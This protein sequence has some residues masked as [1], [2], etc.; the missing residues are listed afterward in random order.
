[1]YR[2]VH[3]ALLEDVTNVTG[4]GL[5]SYAQVTWGNGLVD[6]DNDGD[7]DLYI[8]CGHLYDNVEHFD[9]QSSYRATNLLYENVGQGKFLEV[10]RQAGSGLAVKLSSRGAA[11]DDLDND[12]DVDI[13]VLNSRSEPTLLRNESAHGNHWIELVLQGTTCNRDGVGSQVEVV[14]DSLVQ[15][16]EVHSGRGYQGHFGSVLHFGLGQRGRVH[17]VRVRWLGGA[18]E[19]WRDLTVDRRHT[20]RQGG[21]TP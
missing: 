18:T 11:F 16:D 10:S 2:N 9:D 5:G 4:A 17:E 14:A 20:L 1:L 13:V 19:V 3:G 6:F 7:R 12:G 8:A 15:V 21:A